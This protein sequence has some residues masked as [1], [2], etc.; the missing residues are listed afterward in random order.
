[1]LSKF[2]AFVVNGLDFVSGILELQS[3]KKPLITK[4]RKDENTKE[5]GERAFVVSF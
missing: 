1:M 2:R 4:T 5:E 3:V